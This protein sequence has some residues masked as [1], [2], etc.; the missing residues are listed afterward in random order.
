[1]E[2]VEARPAS[3]APWPHGVSIKITRTFFSR[4]QYTPRSPPLAGRAPRGKSKSI[5][6]YTEFR[7]AGPPDAG[8]GVIG[9]IYLDVT[10][11]HHDLYAKYPGQ[12]KKWPGPKFRKTSIPHPDYAN[13][14]LWCSLE[15]TSFGW[16]PKTAMANIM[17]A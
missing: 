1:M 9:D 6:P 11:N 12:W 5:V 8:F 16:Y 14:F 2:S 13:R 4:A 3:E 10:P 7:G 15:E 17:S